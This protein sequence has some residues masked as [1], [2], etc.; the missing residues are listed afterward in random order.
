[1]FT[2]R[3]TASVIAL[4]CAAASASA[5]QARQPSSSSSVAPA[6]KWI[7]G[8]TFDIKVGETVELT[9]DRIFLRF[10]RHSKGEVIFIHLGG[11]SMRVRLGQRIGL[12][13][14]EDVR[15]SNDRS[16]RSSRTTQFSSCSISAL[17]VI[18]PTGIA[19][20]ATFRLDC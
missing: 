2:T 20:L 3:L 1:M 11:R 6:I 17:N 16:A 4:C 15:M 7:K 13:K 8:G 5:Q 19:P 9:N 18:T 14:P 12:P 10:D